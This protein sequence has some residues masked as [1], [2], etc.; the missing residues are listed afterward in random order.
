MKNYR[1]RLTLEPNANGVYTVTSPD[2]PGLV[3]EGRT[4]GE[5]QAN[6]QEALEALFDAWSELG[7]PIPQA[8]QPISNDLDGY[9]RFKH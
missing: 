8:L 5:I 6:V 2:I 4:A 9:L 7:K 3:T 1:L